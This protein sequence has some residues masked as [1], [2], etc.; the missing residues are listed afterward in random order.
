M[1][2][3]KAG[4]NVGYADGSAKTVPTEHVRDQILQLNDNF[5]TNTTNANIA[6]KQMWD[7][8]DRF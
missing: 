2:S 8:F 6:V 4:L 3:H 1:P 7:K 5:N